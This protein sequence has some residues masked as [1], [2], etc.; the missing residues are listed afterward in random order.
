M[1]DQETTE[2]DRDRQTN[3]PIDQE[4]SDGQTDGQ[5][6]DKRQMYGQSLI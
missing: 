1:G 4:T 2:K 5:K 6:A 3:G